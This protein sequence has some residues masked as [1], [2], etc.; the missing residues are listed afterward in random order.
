V[1]DLNGIT[2][3]SSLQR[4]VVATILRQIVDE[5]TGPNAINGLVYLVALDE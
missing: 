5:R 2:G 3:S 4:F 1:I